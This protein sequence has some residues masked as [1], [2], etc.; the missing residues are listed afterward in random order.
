M[1]DVKTALGGWSE[2]CLAGMVHRGA[3]LRRPMPEGYR[4]RGGHRSV[5][6]YALPGAGWPPVAAPSPVPAV[7]PAPIARAVSRAA[8]VARPLRPRIQRPM[9]SP[10]A[11][12]KRRPAPPPTVRSPHRYPPARRV[13]AVPAVP[14]RSGAVGV[15]RVKQPRPA[16]L[17]SLDLRVGRHLRCAPGYSFGRVRTATKGITCAVILDRR[18]AGETEEALAADYDIPLAEVRACAR[19]MWRLVERDG[20]I[21]LANPARVNP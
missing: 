20:L 18:L 4:R 21:Y 14:G 7:R 3:A 1:C 17:K 8:S 6:L 2:E 12:P 19:W 5:F 9:P 16:G 11:A 13:A 15:R 10:P